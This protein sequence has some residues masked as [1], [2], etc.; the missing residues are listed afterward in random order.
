MAEETGGAGGGEVEE[1]KICGVDHCFVEVTKRR[2]PFKG[3]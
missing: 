3:F 1:I 2:V